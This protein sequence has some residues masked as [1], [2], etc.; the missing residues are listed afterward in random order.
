MKPLLTIKETVLAFALLALAF[1]GSAA[2]LG[3]MQGAALIGRPLNLSVPVQLGDGEDLAQPC[4]EAD[5]FH[6]DNRQDPS[7]V[8]VTLEPTAEP[9]GAVVRIVSSVP[10]DEPLVTVYLRAGCSQKST[11]RYVLLADIVS[12]V[13]APPV[14]GATGRAAPSPLQSGITAQTAP[15]AAGIAGSAAAAPPARRTAAPKPVAPAAPAALASEAV[16]AAPR[17]AAVSARADKPAKLTKTQIARAPAR[18]RLK[19]DM[20]DLSQERDPTLKASSELLSV[21]TADLQ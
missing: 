11:R 3:R 10:V 13:V 5:V 19:V 20:L 14:V 1:D 8:R 9:H 21:P 6:A 15:V 4:L 12:D 18:S 2:T 7:R 17:A 16:K